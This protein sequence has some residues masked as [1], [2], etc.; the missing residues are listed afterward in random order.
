MASGILYSDKMTKKKNV[1]A[2]REASFKV[3]TSAAIERFWCGI[4]AR[5]G[6]VRIYSMYK[7]S[8]RTAHFGRA[9]FY[10]SSPLSPGYYARY[11]YSWASGGQ[12]I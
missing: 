6:F 1:S 5:G 3:I 9:S 11:I 8:T 12:Y 7:K 4:E 2:Y 10:Y